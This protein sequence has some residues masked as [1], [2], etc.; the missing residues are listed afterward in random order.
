MT[1]LLWRMAVFSGA[2]A[3]H[4]AEEIK[5]GEDAWLAVASRRAPVSDCC[6]VFGDK[7][8]GS[9]LIGTDMTSVDDDDAGAADRSWALALGSVQRESWETQRLP[10]G[11]SVMNAKPP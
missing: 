2:G 1:R 5:V 8:F 6:I 7:F 3:G 11:R 10:H 9:G 4:V